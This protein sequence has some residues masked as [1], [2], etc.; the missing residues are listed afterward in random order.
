MC[1]GCTSSKQVNPK[2]FFSVC[3]H[4]PWLGTLAQYTLGKKSSAEFAQFDFVKIIFVEP[5]KIKMSKLKK[6][7]LSVETN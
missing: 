2:D 6:K 7:R 4:T 3:I 1:K 5:L